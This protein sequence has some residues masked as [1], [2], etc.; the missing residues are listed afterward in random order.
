[1][2][3]RLSITILLAFLIGFSP[4][5][6]VSA[7][8]YTVTG[9]PTSRPSYQSL[10]NG[11]VGYTTDSNVWIKLS[12]TVSG[13]KIT[14]TATKSS[15]TFNN[16]ISAVVRKD[17]KLSGSSISDMG[18]IVGSG[19]SSS[20]SSSVSITT[21]AESGTHTY[22]VILS[23]GSMVFY[24][25]SV[26]VKSSTVNPTT[27]SS[28]SPSNGATG[29]ATSGTFSW[30]T[31][32]NDGGSSLS[33]D[34]YKGTST[35]NMTLYKS[36]SGK[37]CSYSG[38]SA[39]TKY[40]W[41][42]IVYNGSG[43]HTQSSTWSFTTKENTISNPTTPTSPS[44][45]NG[46]TG[47][48]TSGTFSWST[49]AN[50]GGSSLSYDLYKGTSTSNMTLYKSGSGK[51]CSYSGF[52]AGTKY[53]WKVIVYNGS[54]GHTQSS[55]WSFTT[56]DNTISNP[57]TPTSPSPSNGATGVATS[58]TF[59]WSTS[60]NDGGSSLSYDLYK[61][62]STSNM[63]LYKSGSGTSCSYSGFSANTK[64]YWKV[65]VYNGSGGHIQSPVWNFTT[66]NTE[67]SLTSYTA[68]P[69]ATT[70]PASD[71]ERKGVKWLGAT[72]G[73]VFIKTLASVNGNTI[74]FTAKKNSGTFNNDVSAVLYK[75]MI[76]E[77]ENV[78]VL[79]SSVGGKT[80]S[81]G[82]S[83]LSVQITPDFTSGCHSYTFLLTSGSMVFYTNPV[84]VTAS[85][86]VPT[87]D[88]MNFTT[89][90]VGTT[91]FT[92]KWPAVPGA[93]KY[94]IQVKKASS[95]SY[96]AP[97]YQYTNITGT[98]WNVAN[99]Q[100]G[101]SYHFRVQAKN[102]IQ[103]GDWSNSSREVVKTTNNTTLA[104]PDYSTFTVTDKTSTSFTAHWGK[105][106][107]A[108]RY[109]LKIRKV[110]EQ[111]PS[112]SNY[113]SIGTQYT[114]ENLTPNTSYQFIVQAKND[115]KVSEWSK[116]IQTAVKT[117]NV[118]TTT[119]K[120][121]IFAV[122]GFDGS[123]PL[124]V[125][126]TKHYDVWVIN[127]GNEK[128]TGTFILKEGSKLIHS[129]KNISLQSNEWA[130]YPLE[131][132]YTP[133]TA[134][135][136]ALNLYYKTNDTGNEISIYD[137]GYSS[138][139]MIVTVKE[140][141]SASYNLK[142][143][144]EIS[145]PSSINWGSTAN[146]TAKIINASSNEWSG[147]LYLTDDGLTIKSSHE[148]IKAGASIPITCTGWSPD[149]PESHT[150]SVYY[151]TDGAED[152]IQVGANGFSLPKYISV[153]NVDVA[154]TA[155]GAI[156]TLISKEC[157]PTLVNEGDEVFYYYRI[158]DRE[159]KPLKGMKA[160]FTCI[161][162]SLKQNVETLPS[163]IN[164]LALLCLQT[165]GNNA[166]ANRGQNVRFNC[167][168]VIDENNNKVSIVNANSEDHEFVLGIYKGVNHF[169]EG[170]ESFGFKLDVGVGGKV[171]L[172]GAGSI[173]AG[174]S[175]PLTTTI[176]YKDNKPLTEI[177]SEKEADFSGEIKLS[178]I[179]E[180]SAG[181]SGGIKTSTTYNWDHPAKTTIAILL[182]MFGHYSIFTSDMAMRSIM[183]IE[184][185]FGVKH[186]EG[187]YDDIVEDYQPTHAFWGREMAGKAN[188]KMKP[189]MTKFAVPSGTLF[190]D[191]KVP[192][193]FASSETKFAAVA[194]AK[195]E[196]NI[197]RYDKSKSTYGTK[198]QFKESIKVDAVSKL[199]GSLSP[200]KG[201]LFKPIPDNSI[202]TADGIYS[203]SYNRN[204]GAGVSVGL[205]S[206]EEEMYT[207]SNMQT[208]DKISTSFQWEAGFKLST[209]QL[210][211][212][213]CKNWADANKGNATLEF[214]GSTSWKWKMTSKGAF[215]AD[216]QKIS[217][218]DAGL[219]YPVFNNGDY[220][221]AKPS[222]YWKLLT[223]DY[224]TDN[225]RIVTDK[226]KGN[227]KLKDA[228]KIE[229]QE[230]EKAFV[231]G[232]IPIVKW[233]LAG[234]IPVDV[235][236][237]AG[238]DLFIS[239]YP[240]EIYYSVS[241]KCFFPVV[242]RNNLDV[243]AVIKKGTEFLRNK[244]NEA[245]GIEDKK[246]ISNHAAKA[247]NMNDFK[248]SQRTLSELTNKNLPH[249]SGGGGSSA[250]TK[251]RAPQL[252]GVKQ[253]DICTFSFRVNDQTQNFN[254][255]TSL[256]TNHFYPMGRLLGIT[257][258]SD[259]LF[260]V[261]EVFNIQAVE[262]TDTLKTTKYGK[263][264]L[265]T[266]IGADDLTPFGFTIDTP[267][268]VYQED[269][270]TSIWHYVGPAGTTL[271]VDKMGSYMMATSIKNDVI[272][273][274]ITM[275]FS[276]DAG[277]IHMTVTDNIAIRTNSL[278][279]YVNG[280]SKEAIMI[281]ETSFEVQLTPEDLD[282]RLYVTASVYDLAGNKKEIVQVFQPRK[283]EKETDED[284]I[285]PDTDISD[286]NNVIYINPVS[287]KPGEEL[288]L[289]VNMK[290]AVP[291]E[292]FSFDLT[293]P[294]GMSF[295]VDEDGF[296]EVSRGLKRTSERKTS[297]FE[298]NI[299][300]NG[301][302]RVLLA[303][304]NGSTFSGNDGEVLLVKVK[305]DENMPNG[306]YPL[307]LTEIA[308]SDSDA[309][310]YNLEYVKSSIN[311]SSGLKGDVNLDGKVD[312]SDI[313][314]VINT[315]AGDNTYRSTANVNDDGNV[316][317]SDIVAIIN[318]IAGM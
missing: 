173:S 144:Q 1:M 107:G 304:T 96:S 229:K 168:G 310:S 185:W 260:V 112:F 88:Y 175:F 162:P 181:V 206:T 52:S 17:F 274:N 272:D 142:L 270:G 195:C 103:S 126:D 215:A 91:G 262:G 265:D 38:F 109:A 249:F 301:N 234:F 267:M 311:I 166:F 178:D 242:L 22:A 289:S 10:S 11:W 313:V 205:S 280:E 49:S 202:Q 94:A 282:Y 263:I 8:T 170:I 32:A 279:V 243:A 131:C 189:W 153:A 51:S 85:G 211:N 285:Y 191:L 209:S 157:A 116:D 159:G 124:Y 14:F 271:M 4:F 302:L 80:A 196:P 24:T 213:L 220:F 6:S 169:T 128:W 47:V 293:L 248:S 197:V 20:G 7:Q 164:G 172:E 31:S 239:Y 33:Y 65:I 219:I 241:D 63:T 27:P 193:E 9:S 95:G 148:T 255:G 218:K 53:Y 244:F 269:P 264:K 203:Y 236:L 137:D 231:K 315:I 117:N 13:S 114:F 223:G 123:T 102:N 145:C 134:G 50:D 97:D 61:G 36:G 25:N 182:N 84:Y 238:I 199:F 192:L 28:P 79:G 187:F 297:T 3:K 46:A 136:F 171:K 133:T 283:P 225:L 106:D 111:Y 150:I 245:F 72:T 156:V 252:L 318:I 66:N 296:P 139:A 194:S 127:K 152:R 154:T 45:S 125:N 21:S 224:L 2:E 130:A 19:S 30:S 298:A 75:D 277:I 110:G 266:H 77:D 232:S 155:Q 222:H 158:T 278:N 41:K 62:T 247:F 74:T 149:S 132:D 176:K 82:S 90:N 174:V 121:A 58:G 143:A 294:E 57:T 221:I 115:T 89:T 276:K 309:Q 29:V 308:M 300:P 42:V 98:S 93:T 305:V 135:S 161:G 146:I 18:T 198:R 254:D 16:S 15:G 291:M 273:P 35:S 99:L 37:S 201:T 60:A 76:I 186:G 284:Y 140:K 86:S 208:L 56:K 73:G 34:L 200:A 119:A 214:G 122:K 268:D 64:Y 314:A 295:V 165:T 240:S 275:S 70:Q 190:P 69:T 138:K 253:D 246:E 23:S 312:I 81:S 286:L 120:L 26:T 59:S 317:I 141:P 250:W 54:G 210:W 67:I 113:G 188:L 217:R 100:P 258:Q 160:Q 303:S 290:N 292:G 71:V 316:D 129:W 287:A 5:L 228:F 180:V 230:T 281:N 288:T 108:S 87:P 261:S 212:Y 237:D 226:M 235:T 92:A 163:N 183:A 259:T 251:R 147:T 306:N 83:S 12:A 48:A 207:S 105:V 151:K 257:D 227:Y 204:W 179:F 78:T 39:G 68:Y 233:N 177:E 167:E 256:Q 104:T 307:I 43:G 101:T 55:T 184:N 216:L 299:Q 118:Q 44:P 40:Y